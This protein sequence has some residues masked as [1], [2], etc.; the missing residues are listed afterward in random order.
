MRKKL[1]LLSILV[2]LLCTALPCHAQNVNS[3][4]LGLNFSLSDD[5]INTPVN[6]GIAFCHN[7]SQN[8]FVTVEAVDFDWAW[9][10]DLTSANDLKTICDQFFSPDRLSASMSAANGIPVNVTADSVVDGYETYNNVK[11]YRYELAYTAHTRDF[12]DTPFYLSS[13]ITAKNGKLYFITYKR[14]T[15]SNHFADISALLDTLSYQNGEIKIEINKE[16]I[17]PD[18]S[19]MILENRTL[20]PIRAIAEK[21]GYT[22][23]WDGANYI[24]TLTSADSSTVLTFGIGS[25]IALKNSDEIIPLDVPAVIMEDRTYLPV[26]AV[27]E[28]MKAIVNWNDATKTVEITKIGN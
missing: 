28:A 25:P 23:D 12:G 5:W 24:V 20:V 19:P 27:T 26:R 7:G 4:E 16:L 9:S 18:S 2:L 22:V 8:E 1:I 14:N 10:L 6:S 3:A 21:M 11:Y 13:L 15:I 17:S